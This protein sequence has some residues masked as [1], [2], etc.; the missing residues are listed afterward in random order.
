MHRDPDSTA[1]PIGWIRY[2]P[3]QATIISPF[4]EYAQTGTSSD[5]AL[6]LSFAENQE[7]PVQEMTRS[8]QYQYHPKQVRLREVKVRR[9]ACRLVL[10]KYLRESLISKTKI[11]GMSATRI[12]SP[13]K[14]SSS[15]V[16]FILIP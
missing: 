4:S 6:C 3:D 5:A 11:E 8:S 13:F 10:H 12:P 7:W 16:W 15:I 1:S 14:A 2:G 9:N